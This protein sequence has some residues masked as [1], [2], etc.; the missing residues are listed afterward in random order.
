[1]VGSIV[2]DTIYNMNSEDF[3]SEAEGGKY[4]KSVPV[5]SVTKEH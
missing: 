4:S 5:F 3:F 2:Y 1:M